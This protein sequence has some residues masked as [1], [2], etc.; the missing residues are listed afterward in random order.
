[1]SDTTFVDGTVI[2][3]SWLN[4]VNDVVYTNAG[5]VGG[6]PNTSD[7]SK[8]DALIG[9]K[10][11]ATG[12]VGLTAHDWHELE[13][14]TPQEFGAVGDGS[15]LDDTPIS[16]MLAAAKLAGKPVDFG[17]KSYAISAPVVLDT[18][19]TF[20]IYSR[21]AT[22]V[23]PTSAILSCLL[24]IKNCTD[25]TIHGRLNISG[26]YNTNLTAGVW[27]HADSGASSCSLIEIRGLAFS[28][29][30]PAYRIGDT[31]YADK[32][33]SE[34]NIFGG[35]TYGC[36][37]VVK[38]EGTQTVVN[39][40][41]CTLNSD[42]GGGGAPWQALTQ[43]T[44]RALGAV[45]RVTGGEI[46]HASNAGGATL[47]V[48]P[49]TSATYGNPYGSISCTNVLIESA[50]QIA[51]SSNPGVIST[52]TNGSIKLIACMGYHSAN[53]FA[54]IQTGSDYAGEIVVQSCNFY[55]GT[56]RT[57][58]NIECANDA[59]NVY[60]D[61]QSFGTNFLAQLRGIVGGTPH[62]R[63]KF[64]LNVQAPNNTIGS[65]VLG[66]IKYQTIV[67]TNDATRYTTAYSTSTGVFTTPT[68]GLKDIS[69]RLGFNAGAATPTDIYIY[70][71]G[72][73]EGTQ[74]SVTGSQGFVGFIPSLTAGDTLEI[75][76]QPSGAGITPG[77]NSFNHMKIMASN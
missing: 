18:Y 60:C 51:I 27:I 22:L 13:S 9:V 14:L 70:V 31:S 29:C 61:E 28:G 2:E 24:E 75:R 25:I 63:N 66:T 77:A 32:T 39:F 43:N 71:N 42:Y 35:Y 41:G 37:S 64:L 12:A 49:V 34:I 52:P 46:N 54:F 7:V 73:I 16:L 23:G 62:F 21:G 69:V 10:R 58:A 30:N 15:T 57:Q 4:D 67:N 33:V 59:T 50:A 53:S 40:V 74:M 72:A 6:L 36:P 45:V 76:A 17:S 56:A 65:G 5:G 20:N 55:A 8:G 68:G 3:P 26:R 44:I 1:M 48:E 38:A 19:S 47:D 11:V